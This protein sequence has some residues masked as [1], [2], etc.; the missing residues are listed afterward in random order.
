MGPLFEGAGVAG[1]A[2]TTAVVDPA[3]L[4]QPL[5]VTVTLYVPPAAVVAP[6]IDGF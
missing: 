5:T 3:E 6:A 2:F 1:M 4:V